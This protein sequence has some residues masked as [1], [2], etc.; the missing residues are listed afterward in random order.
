MHDVIIIG[1]GPAGMSAAIYAAANKLKTLVI[2]KEL[3]DRKGDD[4]EIVGQ[5]EIAQKFQKALKDYPKTLELKDKTEVV[6]LEKNVVSFSVEL[7]SGL[8]F[9]GKTVIIAS[10]KESSSFDMLTNKDAHDNIKAD[11]N[12]N[13][14]IPGIFAVGDCIGEESKGVLVCAGE[15]AKAALSA[16]KYLRRD[17]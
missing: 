9:Y 13:T 12:M 15:G 6:T 14:S 7:A 10:G 17:Q 4:F 5:T 1:C 8:I 2:A 16:L 11:V 3:P